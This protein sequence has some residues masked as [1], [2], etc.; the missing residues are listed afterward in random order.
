MANRGCYYLD[1]V[2]DNLYVPNCWSCSVL[3]NGRCYGC[4]S[5][6]C[7]VYDGGRCYFHD[8]IRFYVPVSGIC[9]V[10]DSGSC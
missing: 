9:Y 1:L 3:D 4:G 2:P 8:I 5:R 10:H 6:R 7:Y